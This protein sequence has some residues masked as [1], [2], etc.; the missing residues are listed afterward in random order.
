M[1]LWIDD[2]NVIRRN[3]CCASSLFLPLALLYLHLETPELLDQE[4]RAWIEFQA[5]WDSGCDKDVC[6]NISGGV[7]VSELR[8][9]RQAPAAELWHRIR[10][11]MAVIITNQW[12]PSQSE[13]PPLLL[14]AVAL[15]F[16]L[17]SSQHIYL[18]VIIQIAAFPQCSWSDSL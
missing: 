7:D 12:Q 9:C 4:Q 8:S 3:F 2:R 6:W 13:L 16:C 14:A 17:R 10:T 15:V 5:S 1:L 11:R 18:T